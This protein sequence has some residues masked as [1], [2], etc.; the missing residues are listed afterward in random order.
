MK[1]VIY[2]LLFISTVSCAQETTTPENFRNRNKINKTEYGTDL[3]LFASAL[4]SRNDSIHIIRNPNDISDLLDIKIDTIFYGSNNNKVVFLALLTKKN[5]NSTSGRQYIGE[6]Y[7][8][9]KNDGIK[10]FYQ[11]KYSSTSTNSLNEVSGMIRKIYLK[12]MNNNLGEYN[13]D[14]NR[15]WKSNIWVEALNM[16]KKRKDFEEMKKNNPEN[17]Y[18]PNDRK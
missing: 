1:S 11:L 9:Y 3:S 14:D 18:D 7:I 13:I 4:K 8:A 2:F 15:F 6:C 10:D 5:E 12:E 17:V 16:E